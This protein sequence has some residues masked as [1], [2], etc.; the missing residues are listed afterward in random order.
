MNFSMKAEHNS[1]ISGSAMAVLIG[2]IGFIGCWFLPIGFWAKL[3][4]AVLFAI[5]FFAGLS[6]SKCY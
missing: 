4:L 6:N 1:I 2:V 3:G 5:I